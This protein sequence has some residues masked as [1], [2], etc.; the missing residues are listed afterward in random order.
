MGNKY[1]ISFEKD[2]T[3]FYGV[4][5]FASEDERNNYIHT[6]KP[7]DIIQKTKSMDEFLTKTS[8]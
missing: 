7:Q 6:M 4:L 3:T 2:E 5:Y 1:K 8:T